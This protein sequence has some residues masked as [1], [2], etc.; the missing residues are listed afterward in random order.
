M[1]GIHANKERK[2]FLVKEAIMEYTLSDLAKVTG[3]KRRT[4]QLW[5]EAGVI[6]TDDVHSGTGTYRRYSQQ[7]A[8]IAC[9]MVPFARL[10]MSIGALVRMSTS[11]RQILTEDDS[12][13]FRWTDIEHSISGSAMSYLLV[14]TWEDG[15][16]V[17]LFVPD[18]DASVSSVCARIGSY[19]LEHEDKPGAVSLSLL[20]NTHL[21]ALR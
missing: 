19:A 1:N 6:L 17:T 2:A 4:L 20:V 11:I 10:Q 16:A 8:A 21:K 9:L 15:T 3:A 12:G 18:P 5:A 13:Q 14:S 7:E